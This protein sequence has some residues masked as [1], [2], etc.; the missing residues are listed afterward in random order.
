MRYGHITTL[1]IDRLL[2]SFLQKVSLGLA[3]AFRRHLTLWARFL[4][5]TLDRLD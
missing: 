1:H 3:N 2:S 5:R 4:R